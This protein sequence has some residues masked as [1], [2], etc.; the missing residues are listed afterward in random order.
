MRTT[1]IFLANFSPFLD[2]DKNLEAYSSVHVEAIVTG[3]R[4]KDPAERQRHFKK[5]L[6][7]V[8]EATTTCMYVS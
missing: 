6:N 2:F 8:I 7:N 3:I 1:Y 5:T 4:M